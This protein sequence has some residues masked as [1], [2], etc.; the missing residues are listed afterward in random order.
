MAYPM[1][2]DNGYFMFYDKS[3]FTEDD[4]K[5]LDRM[6][7]VAAAAGK[8]ITMDFAAWY[9]FSFFQGA[10]FEVTMNADGTNNCNWNASG[11]TDVLQAMIDIAA[12][13]GFISL[14]DAE[15]QT[16]I[17]D[18]SIIAGIN[19]IWN[20]ANAQSAWGE[21]YAA[22][23][24]PTFTMAG[25]QV[26]MAAFSGFKLV[27]VNAFSQNTGWAML[28]AEWLTNEANQLTRFEVRTQ[29][30]SNIN[31][32]STD[33][34]KADPALAA[35][36]AQMQFAVPQDVGGNYWSSA[37][38]VGAIARQGNPDGIDLQEILNQAVEGITGP[39]G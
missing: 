10:G 34:V 25:N 4:V 17:A 15:F 8:Q 28:L 33:A 5:S 31:A 19:G 32:A 23:K 24:L 13:P 16:G 35:L 18:G 14:G 9:I 39:A 36:A 3:Y 1:T 2:A 30:P 6:M 7:E 21:N 20:S 29:A 37:D 11:G 12:N 22:S 26:Q 27:G 38:T